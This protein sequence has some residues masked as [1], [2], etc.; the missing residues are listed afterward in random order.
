LDK[1]TS[2]FFTVYV[3]FLTETM[4]L[5]ILKLSDI[6]RPVNP[7]V[8]AKSI[9]FVIFPVTLV[10]TPIHPSILTEPFFL[11]IHILTFKLRLTWPSFYPVSMLFVILPLSFVLSTFRI[12]VDALP[13]PAIARPLANILPAIRLDID[14]VTV[15]RVIAPGAFEKRTVRP[16]HL[17]LSMPHPT[18]PLSLID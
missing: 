18:K 3:V 10:T 1:F 11:P 4:H 17:T 15:S 12:L 16:L 13:I 14:A 6:G 9:L 5:V 7:L 2:V 8:R